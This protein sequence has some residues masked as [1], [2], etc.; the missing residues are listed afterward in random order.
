MGRWPSEAARCRLELALP[1]SERSGLCSRWGW[2]LRMRRA[3]SAS[4]EW[5]AR[6]RRM[7]GSILGLRLVRT[8]G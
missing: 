3:S 2:D 5:I 6:R 4:L 8:P 1:V 7:E